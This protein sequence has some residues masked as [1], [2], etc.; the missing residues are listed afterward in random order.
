MA[1]RPGTADFEVS[2]SVGPKS[3]A[4]GSLWKLRFSVNLHRAG[5]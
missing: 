3:Y 2:D 1:P 5:L 4:R